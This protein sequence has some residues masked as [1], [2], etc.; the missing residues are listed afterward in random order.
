MTAVPIG[1][2]AP[3]AGAIIICEPRMIRHSGTSRLPS[4]S[5]VLVF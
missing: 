3:I 5:P 4:I 1:A 2:A